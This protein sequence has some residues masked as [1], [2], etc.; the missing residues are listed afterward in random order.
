MIKPSRETFPWDSPSE[1][2]P[3]RPL[4]WN[5]T[6][7]IP[8]DPFGRST[9]QGVRVAREKTGRQVEQPSE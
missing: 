6:Q 9:V 1:F 8:L 3:S 5:T 2:I 7:T 4:E